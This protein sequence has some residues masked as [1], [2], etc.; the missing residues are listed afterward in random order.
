MEGFFQSY[1]MNDTKEK[2]LSPDIIHEPGTTAK[3]VSNTSDNIPTLAAKPLSP[4]TKPVN[5]EANYAATNK[6]LL[7]PTI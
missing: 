5:L 1:L 7:A 2:T 6:V 4:V 3:N